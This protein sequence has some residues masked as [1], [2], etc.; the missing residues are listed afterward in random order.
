M[1]TITMQNLVKQVYTVRLYSVHLLTWLNSLPHLNDEVAKRII[2][3]MKS[4]N[5]VTIENSRWLLTVVGINV[6]INFLLFVATAIQAYVSAG[7]QR[8]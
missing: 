8:H 7:A 4:V 1:M 3:G 6:G 2:I 5:Q